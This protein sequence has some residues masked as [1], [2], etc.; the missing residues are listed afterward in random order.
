MTET[1]TERRLV[2]TPRERIDVLL[3]EYHALYGLAQF[4]MSALDK[5][6]PA[7]GAAIVAF[8]SGVPVLPD[9]AGLSRGKAVGGRTGFETV[10][11]VGLASALIGGTCAYLAWWIH[12]IEYQ[13][14]LAYSTYLATILIHIL[15]LIRSTRK[16][17][18]GYIDAQ[19]RL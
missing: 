3:A 8:L 11:A 9:P 10:T 14:S 12:P 7:A 15:F 13:T 1:T 4:R 2:L 18:Y 5:R 19:N 17:R 6:V 16:Y